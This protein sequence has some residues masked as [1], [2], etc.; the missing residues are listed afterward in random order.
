MKIISHRGN[1]DGVNTD[2]ENNPNQID[3]VINTQGCTGFVL[4]STNPNMKMTFQ[5]TDP[6][7]STVDTSAVGEYLFLS[8][9]RNTGEIDHY[10]VMIF[11]YWLEVIY[12]S[13]SIFT[14]ERSWF[15]IDF[16]TGDFNGNNKL[17]VSFAYNIMYVYVHHYI[18]EFDGPSYQTKHFTR[19][20]ED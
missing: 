2:T 6:Q 14:T 15:P 19:L 4:C 17:D 7:K 8:H 9:F 5:K 1:I 13:Q 3:R 10:D 11:E 18:I 12:N 16:S 20:T